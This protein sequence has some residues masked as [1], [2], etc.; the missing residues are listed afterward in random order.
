MTDLLKM[1]HSMKSLYDHLCANVM[2]EYHLTRSELDILLFLHN[3]PELDS[4]KDIVEKRGLV[5][6]QAS[7]GIEKLIQ[8]GYLKTI[9]DQKDKRRYHL[10][11]L[12]S[13]MPIIQAGLKAQERF[14]N[15]L[16]KGVSDED[17]V[18]WKKVLKQMSE[19]MIDR[20]DEI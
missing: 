1:V 8:K 11:L 12:D 19:N 3:N 16:F 6:S 9:Q 5:K 4:A 20:K 18:C 10:Y 17:M 15:V 14:Y 13:S 2:Q 7:M